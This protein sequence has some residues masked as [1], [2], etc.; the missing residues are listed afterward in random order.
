MEVIK[1][2]FYAFLRI[3]FP[4]LCIACNRPL[5]GNEKHLCTKCLIDLPLTNFWQQPDNPV[6]KLLWGRAKIEKASAFLY[7]EKGSKYQQILYHLKYKGRKEIG[8]LLGQY[9]GQKL[10]SNYNEIE[11]IMPVPLHVRKERLRGYNQSEMLAIGIAEIM[12]KPIVKN[13]VKRIYFTKTQ[14][15]KGR[16]E[17]WQN[18]ENIFQVIK[19]EMIENKHILVVDDVITTGSTTESLINELLKIKGV[20]V[21]I[22]ALACA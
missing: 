21:S 20:K 13:A 22:A 9:Y 7:F 6:E 18:V 3:L 4:E 5:V 10:L 1:K 2:Y 12:N 11:L 15:R 14:T 19:P 16:Y 8:I 17:R